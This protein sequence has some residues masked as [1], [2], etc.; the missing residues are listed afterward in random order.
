M[1]GSLNKGHVV[2][3]NSV[4]CDMVL[5]YA[6]NGMKSDRIAAYITRCLSFDEL[7]YRVMGQAWITADVTIPDGT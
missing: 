4:V 2:I 3:L 1:I 5:T 6:N 7:L